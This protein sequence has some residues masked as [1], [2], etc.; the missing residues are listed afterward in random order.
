MAKGSL[1]GGHETGRKGVNWRKENPSRA[2]ISSIAS[3]LLS[4]NT[5][6]VEFKDE[7]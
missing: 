4:T 3:E 7:T 6:K 1:G 2:E 5:L